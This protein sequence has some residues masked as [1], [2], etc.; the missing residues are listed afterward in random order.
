MDSGLPPFDTLQQQRDRALF[1]SEADTWYTELRKMYQDEMED[2]N[3]GTWPQPNSYD[4][5]RNSFTLGIGMKSACFNINV[6]QYHLNNGTVV[7]FSILELPLTYSM[8]LFNSN[9]TPSDNVACH[10]GLHWPTWLSEHHPLESSPLNADHTA[11]DSVVW[12]NDLD[13]DF[14]QW[15]EFSE[16]G[17]TPV[18]LADVE[19]R[20]DP[21]YGTS[22]ENIQSQFDPSETIHSWFNS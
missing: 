12:P 5:Q 22:T 13:K 21:S 19:G 20:N 17:G 3:G 11:A 10:D 18:T 1:G 15:S 16:F 9:Y 6:Y 7:R 8:I 4:I 14:G 2:V